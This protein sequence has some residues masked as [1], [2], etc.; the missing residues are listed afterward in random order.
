MIEAYPIYIMN[1]ISNSFTYT[2]YCLVCT[3]AYKH[4]CIQFLFR[5]RE[6]LLT[7]FSPSVYSYYT[8]LH[9]TAWDLNLSPN[10]INGLILV[11]YMY[12]NCQ[13][14]YR[15]WFL[16]FKYTLQGVYV[17]QDN[18]FRF[19]TQISNGK[20][21]METAPKVCTLITCMGCPSYSYVKYYTIINDYSEWSS[22][23]SKVNAN[24]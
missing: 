11:A 17:L 1:H 13:F 3:H 18:K 14:I 15:Y 6:S 16:V 20:Q 10:F 7:L 4:T 5:P 19:L 21:F 9:A 8:L 2:V 23:Q 12:I 24:A 22:V